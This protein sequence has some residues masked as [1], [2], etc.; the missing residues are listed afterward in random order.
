VLVRLC[1]RGPVGAL[2]FASRWILDHYNYARARVLLGTSD[3]RGRRSG[4]ELL[5]AA[6][7][8]TVGVQGPHLQQDLSGL[9]PDFTRAWVKEILPG[10]GPPRDKAS[11]RRC[12]IMVRTT[13]ARSAELPPSVRD[14]VEY[15]IRFWAGPG[16]GPA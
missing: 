7:S 2:V 8:A 6:L 11:L 16:T 15:W 12:S 10:G 9:P 4:P 3:G 1:V 14:S 13:A 5:P